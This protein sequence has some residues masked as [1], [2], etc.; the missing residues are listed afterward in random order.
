[1]FNIWLDNVELCNCFE[2]SGWHL[3]MYRRPHYY[4]PPHRNFARW[5][6]N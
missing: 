3:Q 4:R 1:M 2:S 5:G 6:A